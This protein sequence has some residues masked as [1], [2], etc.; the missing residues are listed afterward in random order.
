[1]LED[2]RPRILS[3]ALQKQASKQTS[4]QNP[5]TTKS[6]YIQHQ[7]NLKNKTKQGNNLFKLLLCLFSFVVLLF[8][9]CPIML[10]GLA[11]NPWSQ[12]ILLLQLPEELELG[13]TVCRSL[14]GRQLHCK[15]HWITW[16]VTLWS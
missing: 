10:S 9:T 16:P 14:L 15:Q 5:K 6:Y 11:L 2:E 13:A 4:K 12:A 1:M 3:L 8:F 7:I